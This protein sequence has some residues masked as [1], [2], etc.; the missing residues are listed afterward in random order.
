MPTRS[1]YDTNNFRGKF[2][3]VYNG[4]AD[5]F[6]VFR[7]VF[8]GHKSLDACMFR[9]EL[10]TWLFDQ[11]DHDWRMGNGFGDGKH[12]PDLAVWSRVNNK[13][14]VDCFV[15]LK[16]LADVH[17]FVE[18]FDVMGFAPTLVA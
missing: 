6:H 15:L 5:S 10:T 17:R 3:I 18:A 8:A 1:P 2:Q 16:S 9:H 14:G 12:D 4:H 7:V 13:D 11:A